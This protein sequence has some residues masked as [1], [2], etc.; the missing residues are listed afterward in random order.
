MNELEQ[1]R[2]VL[3]KADAVLEESIANLEKSQTFNEVMVEQNRRLSFATNWR[4]YFTS[5]STSSCATR[6]SCSCL[7]K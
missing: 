2:Q 3:A 7:A 6:H 5:L 4:Q 1:A